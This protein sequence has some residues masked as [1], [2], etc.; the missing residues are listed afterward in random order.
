MRTLLTL[1]L[2]FMVGFVGTI[3]ANEKPNLKVKTELKAVSLEDEFFK[4]NWEVVIPYFI[5]E[6]AKYKMI[7]DHELGLFCAIIVNAKTKSIRMR[8][9]DNFK[10]KVIDLKL[11]TRNNLLYFSS[12]ELGG[13]MEVKKVKG[14][15]ICMPLNDGVRIGDK[16]VMKVYSWKVK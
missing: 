10:M 9:G 5:K 6:N 12:D 11:I 4:N 7:Y 1:L 14:K 8:M 16:Y 15:L 2:I 3:Q 13:V